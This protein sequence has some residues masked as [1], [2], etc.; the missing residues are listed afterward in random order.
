[1]AEYADRH[2]RCLK[3]CFVTYQSLVQE[4]EYANVILIFALQMQNDRS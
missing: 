2:I 3:S 1:M 4:G